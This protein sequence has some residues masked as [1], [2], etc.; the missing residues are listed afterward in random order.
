MTSDFKNY[1]EYVEGAMRFEDNP[2]LMLTF[3]SSPPQEWEDKYDAEIEK[4]E[5]D[6]T[7]F[8]V[9]IFAEKIDEFIEKEMPAFQEYVELAKEEYEREG[10]GI[11]LRLAKKL[12]FD[13][14]EERDHRLSE[15]KKGL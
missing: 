2:F 5:K 12:L 7:F 15:F 8:S 3:W 6:K 1:E 10:G 4:I 13:S 14:P 11:V 9:K